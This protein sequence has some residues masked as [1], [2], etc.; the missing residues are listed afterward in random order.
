MKLT[1]TLRQRLLTALLALVSASA[2][3]ADYPALQLNEEFTVTYKQTSQVWTY[4]ATQDGVVQIVGADPDVFFSPCLN[5]YD[6][7]D[8]SK[9]GIEMYYF[10]PS[11]YEFQVQ[12]DS[13]YYIKNNNWSGSDMRAKLVMGQEFLLSSVDPA[14]GSVFTLKSN[15]N[16]QLLFTSSSVTFTEGELTAA[17]NV[18]KVYNFTDYNDLVREGIFTYSGDDFTGQT[19]WNGQLCAHTDNGI[20]VELITQTGTGFYNVLNRLF[21][22]GKLQ[23]GDPLSLDLHGIQNTL[24]GDLLNGDGNL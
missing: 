10:A 22:E 5:V 11:H 17:G 21:E 1:T 23:A 3:A 18:I 24:T 12:A 20:V 16:I 19:D 6:S 7:L 2:W 13:T 4:T 9:Q 15:G 14:D 8:F